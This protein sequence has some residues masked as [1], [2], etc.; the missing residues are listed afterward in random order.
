VKAVFPLIILLLFTGNTI[1][2]QIGGSSVYGF[3]RLTNSARIAALGGDNISIADGDLNFIYH[4][5]ALLD[6][7]M[8]NNLVLNYVNYFAGINYGY[9]AYAKDFNDAG[10][11]ASG[12]HY[13]NYGKFVKADPSG[14]ITGEFKAFELALN[15][16]WSRPIIDSM[17]T[18]GVNL[19]PIYSQLETYNSFGLALDAGVNYQSNSRLFSASL[20]FKNAGTQIKPYYPGNYEPLPFDL[21]IGISRKLEH[22]PFRFSALLHHIYKWDLTYNVNGNPSYTSVPN[23]GTT[24]TD[25]KFN[26]F[27][28]FFRHTIFGFEFLPSK[29]FEVMLGYNHQRRKEMMVPTRP[30]LVGFSWGIYL[31]ISKIRLSFGQSIYHLAGASNHF[32]L[33][34][35]LTDFYTSKK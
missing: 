17:L 26:V 34:F 28:N 21:Q 30:F 11:F 20:V 3:L 25:Y 9:A 33:S 31:H 8:T 19:K 14:K 4:N 7:S 29:N 35:N 24:K 27:D 32:S 12:L 16:Y 13:I 6:K 5:P 10:V 23:Q 15:L 2:G 22:A 18:I 1:I